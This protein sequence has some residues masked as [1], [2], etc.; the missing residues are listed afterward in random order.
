MTP[1]SAPRYVSSSVRATSSVERDF[2]ASARYGSASATWFRCP[3]SKPPGTSVAAEKKMPCSGSGARI[4]DANLA[5]RQP[6]V[7]AVEA[8]QPRD[9]IGHALCAQVR[10]HRKVVRR[11]GVEAT[12]QPHLA[13]GAQ[14]VDR[15]LQVALALL[16]AAAAGKRV[17]R[18]A[19]GRQR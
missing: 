3:S 8:D 7:P 15:A 11:V 14:Q 9:V 18:Q 19:A 12:A 16:V 17:G 4:L 10:E 1:A 2:T 5:A 6:R 13:G